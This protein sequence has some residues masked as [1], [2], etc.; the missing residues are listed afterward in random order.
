MAGPS[1]C[2]RK[3]WP[4]NAW[5]VRLPDNL[6]RV[7]EYGIAAMLTSVGL[8]PGAQAPARVVRDEPEFRRAAARNSLTIEIQGELELHRPVVVSGHDLHIRGGSLRMAPDFTGRAAILAEGANNITISDLV[9]VGNRGTLKTAL[10][11]PPSNVA[12]ADFYSNNG[13]VF[14]D[15]VRGRIQRVALRFIPSFPI[16]VHGGTDIAIESARIEDSGT[17]NGKGRNNSS[18]GILIEDGTSKFVVRD[19]SILR[20]PGNGIWTHSRAD[21][22]RSRDGV[23]SGNT[24]RETARDA[25]QAGHA[26][27]VRIENNKGSRIGYPVDQIDIEESAVP[28]A[29]DT[30]GNVDRSIYSGN[31][32]ED[33]NGKCIDLDG[34]HDGA[35]T[36]NSCENRG[37]AAEYPYSHFAIV[38]NNSNPDMQSQGVLVE[39]NVMRGFAYGGLFLVGSGHRILRNRFLDLNRAHCTGDASKP[40]CNYAPDEPDLLRSGIYL[41]QHALRPAPATGNEISGNVIAGFGMTKWCIVAAPGVSLAR[42]TIEQNTCAD[43]IPARPRSSAGR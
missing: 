36:R 1:I 42:N 32:F 37:P 4:P 31:V 23:I 25:L 14:R 38:F 16:L 8:L 7:A 41:S 18:G 26:T 11:L 9:I 22:P 39:E 28:V 10:G 40:K 21:S 34:F 2:P 17:L 24:I 13:I 20:V 19:S 12:F 30:A 27:A 15:C 3:G 5:R 43:A 6:R 33:V 35:V 29:I